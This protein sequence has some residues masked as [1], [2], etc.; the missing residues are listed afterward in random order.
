LWGN[1][2]EREAFIIE[3]HK[4][5]PITTV[6]IEPDEYTLDYEYGGKHIQTF[7]KRLK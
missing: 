5:T 3:N 2:A 4:L 6:P 1:R 7:R